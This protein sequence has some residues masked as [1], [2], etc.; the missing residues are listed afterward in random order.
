MTVT[1]GIGHRASP[2]S[3]AETVERLT[4]AIR[5]ADAKL[6]ALV[7]HS[8]EARQVGQSLRDTKLLI[9]GNPAAGTAVMDA[10]P[11]AAI[12]L[13]LRVLIWADDTGAVWMTY[14]TAQWLADRH[15]V[16]PDL[17]TRLGAPE[18]LAT[19]VAQVD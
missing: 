3:V 15:G 6:F 9:F 16:P 14:L 2:Y 1:E 18:A 19:R 17:A 12:D 11:L 7:D 13:P 8:G 10:A 5:N 4:D